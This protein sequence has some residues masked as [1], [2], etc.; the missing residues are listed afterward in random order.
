MTGHEAKPAVSGAIL[1]AARRLAETAVISATPANAGANSRLFRVDTAA[2]LLALKS[3][4]ERTGDLRRRA[5]VE[6][7]T[8]TFLRGRGLDAVPKPLRHDPQG[9]FLL[10]EW[11]EGEPVPA[12]TPADVADAAEFIAQ[13]FAHSAHQDA[14][15][16]P[17]AS[18]A[19]LSAAIVLEQIEERLHRFGPES[20]ISAWIARTLV[21]ALAEARRAVTAELTDPTPLPSR[22]RRLIP[23]DFG[24]HNAMRQGDG[25][26]RYIDFDYFG[27]DDPV[28]LAAD[29]LLHPAMTLTQNDAGIFVRRMAEALPGDTLFID[30]LN[31]HLPLYALRWAL[32]VLNPFRIDRLHELPAAE[33]ARALL[34]EKRIRLAQMLLDRGSAAFR[35]NT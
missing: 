21:P 32:I 33:P 31:R 26:L 35:F 29:T 13:I 6:W 34:R 28:K 12:P 2:G 23:A 25:R 7:Q 14:A 10:M 16:F 20:E 30:R 1:E 11:I 19:C 17:P 8:L 18:E 5:D 3:Y 22:L 15:A 4:P 24:F 27:W 9:R